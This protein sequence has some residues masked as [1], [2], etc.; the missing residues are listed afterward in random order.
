MTLLYDQNYFQE[1][2]E[3]LEQHMQRFQQT[4]TAWEE[5]TQDLPKIL[6]AVERL[7]RRA[8]EALQQLERQVAE[9]QQVFEQYH[10]MQSQRLKLT[11]DHILQ[12]ASALSDQGL[13]LQ[14]QQQLQQL[15]DDHQ[16]TQQQ[17]RQQLHLLQQEQVLPLQQQLH[18]L[19]EHMQSQASLHGRQLQEVQHQL[20]SE[21]GQLQ[22]QIAQVDVRLQD[23]SQQLQETQLQVKH[24]HRHLVVLEDQFNDHQS[25]EQQ[26]LNLWHEP[27]HKN[28]LEVTTLL[29]STQRDVQQVSSLQAAQGTSLKSQLD[30][31][32]REFT[33]QLSGV[34]QTIHSQ[35]ETLNRDLRHTQEKWGRELKVVTQNFSDFKSW[36]LEAKPFTRMFAKPS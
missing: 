31:L 11:V 34:K 26:R 3:R 19:V 29:K 23:T 7:E 8:S 16:Q 36:Y 2:S 12:Q 15:S 9:K 22:E 21:T 33:T 24:T 10:Q 27:F 17:L 32:E 13:V 14:L 1:Q 6:Q 25:G 4:V 35:G 20:V 5:L 30:Q 28:L 18:G